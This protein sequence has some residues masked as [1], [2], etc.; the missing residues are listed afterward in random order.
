MGSP[1][2]NRNRQ[3]GKTNPIVGELGIGELGFGKWGPLMTGVGKPGIGESEAFHDQFIP[4][5]D[6][7]VRGT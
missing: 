5:T 3:K 1:W 2:Q 4:L 6:W 7:V